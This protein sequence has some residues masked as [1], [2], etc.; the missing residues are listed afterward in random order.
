MQST[1]GSTGWL[2]ALLAQFESMQRTIDGRFNTLEKAR[3]SLARSRAASA[4]RQLTTPG[5]LS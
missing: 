5:A 1:I 3:Q 2:L 4:S